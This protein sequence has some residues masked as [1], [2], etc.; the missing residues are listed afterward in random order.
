MDPP[1]HRAEAL[2]LAGAPAS[3]RD[4]RYAMRSA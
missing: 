1:T 3:P 4:N 2:A